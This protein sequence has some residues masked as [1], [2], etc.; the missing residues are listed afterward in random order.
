LPRWNPP[1]LRLRKKRRREEGN[2]KV[3]RRKDAKGRGEWEEGNGKRGMGRGEWEE[4][5]GKRGMGRGEW[6]VSL[7]SIRDLADG[8]GGS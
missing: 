8:F 5:N 1:G 6:V 2:A 4:G 7:K 3:Q